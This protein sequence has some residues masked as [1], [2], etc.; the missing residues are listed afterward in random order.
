MLSDCCQ[1]IRTKLTLVVLFEKNHLRRN[2]QFFP[3]IWNALSGRLSE[4]GPE[5]MAERWLSRTGC[6]RLAASGCSG[7]QCLSLSWV[8]LA[9][10]SGSGSPS[11]TC[12][13][14]LDSFPGGHVTSHQPGSR[15][16]PERNTV[17]R[18]PHHSRS[19]PTRALHAG[20]L[21]NI[22]YS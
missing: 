17:F 13:S 8:G 10:G 19:H 6:V 21:Q 18:Q 20:C 16:S 5:L 2:L 3:W 12:S 4:E 9:K 15:G 14:V 11:P 22:S 1:K 7:Q